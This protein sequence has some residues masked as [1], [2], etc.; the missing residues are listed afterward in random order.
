MTYVLTVNRSRLKNVPK[1]VNSPWIF[2]L[3]ILILV[4]I[5]DRGNL[6]FVLNSTIES[7]IETLPFIGAAILLIAFLQATHSV[8]L[9]ASA[10]KGRES[11]MIVL[12]ALIGALAPLCSC[13]VI[14]LIAALLVA[15]VPLSAIMAFWL[16]SPLMDIPTFVITLAALGWEFALGKTI[17]AVVIGLV[18]GFCTQFLC[19]S[20]PLLT[21]PIRKDSVKRS[22]G[23]DER[24]YEGVPMWN[25]WKEKDRIQT[26]R[27]AAISNSL[28]LVKW[29]SL[30]YVIQ[31]LLVSYFPTE[32]IASFVGNNGLPSI[33]FGALIG[34]PAYLNGYAAPALVA[35]LIDQGMS[36]GAAMAFIVAGAMTCIPAMVAVWSLVNGKVFV[37][38]C[39][40]G[41]LG[42][43]LSGL[44]FS[45][46]VS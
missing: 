36:F 40:F 1:I 37:I 38:Y 34:M 45:T 15:G 5:L 20:T 11:R 33:V 10:F 13:E 18:F 24:R 3:A 42:A 39:S 6:T 41:L 21:E 44:F 26:F 2:I 46:L 4:S 25:F 12:A 16:S 7:L 35:G 23:V 14:P 43:V 22:C 17:A 19:H 30:A 29:L 28:F 8:A 31:S 27:S 32:W 9:V